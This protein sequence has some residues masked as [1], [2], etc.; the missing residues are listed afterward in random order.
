MSLAL[1]LNMSITLAQD[2]ESTELVNAEAVQQQ[3]GGIDLIGQIGGEL[4]DIIVQGDYAYLAV[5]SRVVV[6]DISR[7]AQPTLVGK[8][9]SLYNSISALAIQND[10]V[11]ATAGDK[12]YVFSYEVK[13][14]HHQVILTRQGSYQEPSGYAATD[15]AVKGNYAYVTFATGGTLLL[16]RGLLDIIDVTNPVSPTLV[17][18]DNSSYHP[19]AVS[20][21]GNDVYVAGG[22]LVIYDVSN[23]AF[24]N[25]KG[26][27][28]DNHTDIKDI[29]VA[30][31]Y[32]YTSNFGG[33]GFR[34]L[35]VNDP[36]NI[37]QIGSYNP[38]WGAAGG[39]AVVYP[40]AYVSDTGGGLRI[41]NVTNP[42]QPSEIG[43]YDLSASV[44]GPHL[45]ARDVAVAGNVAYVNI[46][47]S[48]LHIVNISNRTALTK[49]ASYSN[50]PVTDPVSV[51]VVG[52][53][54]YVADAAVG[55][56]ILN[57]AEQSSPQVV[58]HW[59]PNDLP[60]VDVAVAGHY[61]YLLT[62]FAVHVIDIANPSTPRETGSYHDT[63]GGLTYITVAGNYAYVIAQDSGL[64]IL[65]VSNPAR[66]TEVVSRYRFDGGSVILSRPIARGAKLYVTCRCSLRVLDISDP[67]HPT[68]QTAKEI[69]G[70]ARDLAIATYP[71]SS[72]AYLY[73][74]EEPLH[75]LNDGGLRVT[76]LGDL[77]DVGYYQPPRTDEYDSYRP[78]FVAVADQKYEAYL[79]EQAKP[80]NDWVY[81][82][83]LVDLHD[84]T[85]PLKAGTLDLPRR[86]GILAAT[87]D[88]AFVPV[89]RSGLM[90]FRRSRSSSAAIPTTG[91][92]LV[93]RVDNTS[94]TFSAG[95]F[96]HTTTVTHTV[97]SVAQ[98]PPS[99][100][101]TGTGHFYQ[102]SALDNVTGQPAQPGRPYTVTVQYTEA[103]KGAAVVNS[104]ALYYW[105]GSRWEKESSSTVNAT[106]NTVM[107]TP[108]HF[109]TWAVLGETLRFFLPVVASSR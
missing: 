107:A 81:T 27:Y 24:P 72:D 78:N 6:V 94:Y 7:S 67:A 106:A 50:F 103:Q 25:E 37:H 91:G 86:V 56:D 71:H 90:I 4:S 79:V 95:T 69:P 102:V 16:E 80:G 96:A 29:A 88:Y 59:T 19:N 23:P 76:R 51:K 32:A 40:Y 47:G 35:D 18:W 61:A 55:L 26:S 105:N 41:L 93:S 17:G 30:G 53:L 82:L 36:T 77:S 64:L 58:G 3:T 85:N 65:D 97:L 68:Q 73:L 49:S 10:H 22:N 5:G 48:D 14:A 8:T 9:S 100:N 13:V 2:Q 21:A 38:P 99:G 75:G 57:V 101:L 31:H 33:D 62:D 54:A 60:P 12:L 39:I 46:G 70:C 66:P 89:R 52:S 1:L 63:Y 92:S 43:A 42:A 20:I 104:L 84:L 34:V 15:V 108:D 44:H 98:V 45:A 87:G 74:A 83:R 109:S 28:F 11:Y